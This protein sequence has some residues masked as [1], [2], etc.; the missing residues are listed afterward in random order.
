MRATVLFT[1]V[2][3]ALSSAGGQPVNPPTDTAPPPVLREMRG[4]WIATV[5]NID[6]PS[7]PG[8]STWD[9]QA[10]MIAILNR[11]VAAHLNAVMFQVRPEADALY[12]SEL[13]PW[14]SFLS[15]TMGHAPEPYY[16]PLAFV[17]REA[18]A[19]GLEVHA[20][21]NP[22]RAWHPATTG[23][24]APSHVTKSGGA[25]VRRYGSFLWLDP[26]DSAVVERSVRAVL[27]VARRYDVDGIHIDDYFYPYREEDAQGRTIDFPDA[28]TYARYRAAGGR[29]ERNDWRRTNVDAF[30]QRIGREI[31][32]VKP[33][34]R[35]GISPFGIWRPGFPAS[36]RG[37][38]SFA[39]IYADSR[40]WLQAGWVDYLVPQLY[41]P[42]GRPQ[43][44]FSQLLAWWTE[45]NPGG[46]NIWAGLNASLATNT[47]PR[48]RGAYELL[49]QIGRTRA[50]RGATGDVFFSMK[51]LMQ[52]PDSL[53]ERLARDA[54]G[55]P[56]LV[57]ASPWLGERAP[58]LPVVEARI[59][60]AS[61]ESVLDVDPAN[62][63]NA[64]WLWVVQALTPNG[65]TTQILP[66][67]TVTHFLAARAAQPPRDVRVYAVSRTGLLSP[68]ARVAPRR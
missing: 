56:A 63:E 23:D 21:F 64:P 27:D 36:V 39:E 8:L 26:G 33:S 24:A 61:G 47:A 51:T 57:P 13:E 58:S 25:T 2:A 28:D 4:V 52:D 31:H 60:A 9:Q 62:G 3:A 44:D 40:K 66:G 6:W 7:R 65:W 49:D 43:Q 48:G 17:I 34:V 29:L 20:W 37:L 35:F 10:E 30:V 1:L 32:T 12:D 42:I 15:G 53:V 18:H 16:D 59:D 54:Y 11:A 14:S 41:W 50:Q 67:S 46:R 5:A 45:Q 19:R 55:Q 22:Y 38:D 68:A